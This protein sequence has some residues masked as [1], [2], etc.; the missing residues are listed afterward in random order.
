MA[1]GAGSIKRASKLS[2]EAATIQKEMTEKV[3]AEKVSEKTTT[4]KAPAKAAPAK[5]APAN[6][7]PTKKAPVKKAPS[8]KVQPVKK[9]I[10]VVEVKKPSTVNQA[11]RLTEELP[12]HLL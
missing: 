11:C 3:V 6:A 4:K 9:E 12:I 1:V 2:T 8:N 10:P 5:K 7:A